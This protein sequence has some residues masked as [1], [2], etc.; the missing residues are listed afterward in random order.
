MSATVQHLYR[1][2]VKGL[3]PEALD[4]V[5]VLQEE[6]FPGDR[7]YAFARS[8]GVFDA[9]NPVHLAK[10]NFLMLQRDERLAALASRLDPKTQVLTIEHEAGVFEGD[11]STAEG[12]QAAEDFFA[13]YLGADLKSR[14]KLETAPGHSFSDLNAKVISIINLA[15][16]TDLSRHVGAE[17]DPLRFR[18]NV[19]ID[20]LAAW[21]EFDWL[22]QDITLG[23]TRC[24]VVKR[25]QRCAATNVNPETAIR[26][27]NLPKSLLNGY[28]HADLGIY[29][30]VT[31]GG[32]IRLGDS[33]GLLN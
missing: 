28:G 8:A 31:Q 14:P 9:R 22:D 6:T 13:A 17:L 12:R 23:E 11:L 4:H 19:Y 30:S 32:E 29:V 10:T 24:R 15:S 16:V 33:V 3:S 2:P 26:D 18:G 1:Y 27:Q 5:S 21:E 20:G 25:T 7:Q